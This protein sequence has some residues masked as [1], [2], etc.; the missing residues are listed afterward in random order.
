MKII[1]T[2]GT[3]LSL[4]M[5]TGKSTY[6]QGANRDTLSFIFP[7][8]ENMTTLDAAFTTANC[9]SIT[10]I[11][12]DGSESIHKAY[13]IRAEMKKA[14]VEIAPATPESEAVAEERIT[15]SMAQRTYA[16]TQLA[17]LTVLLEGEV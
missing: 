17:A 4:I 9:E 16:E 10:I 7:A 5:V 2:N 15:V 13:T 11:G 6:V 1:L 12:D 14:P 3:E 8:T